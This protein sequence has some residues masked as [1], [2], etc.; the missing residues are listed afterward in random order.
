MGLEQELI[1]GISYKDLEFLSTGKWT[2]RS[3]TGIRKEKRS[4]LGAVILRISCLIGA[5]T[6]NLMATVQLLSHESQG[7]W[8]STQ[9]SFSGTK[10]KYKASYTCPINRTLDSALSGG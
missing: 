7:D 8:T 10:E 9:D 2:C 6:S 4:V 3:T 1:I 5:Y